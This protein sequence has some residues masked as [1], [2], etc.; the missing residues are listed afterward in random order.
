MD[1]KCLHPSSYHLSS[2]EIYVQMSEQTCGTCTYDL[3]DEW[4]TT[5]DKQT[6]WLMKQLHWRMTNKELTWLKRHSYCDQ[7]TGTD[8]TAKLT[9][10][11]SLNRPSKQRL[12]A[13][14]VNQLPLKQ[15][16]DHRL[17]ASTTLEMPTWSMNRPTYIRRPLKRH[18]QCAQTTLHNATAPADCAVGVNFFQGLI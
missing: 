18:M 12:T 11:D 10:F 14:T 15:C 2:Q 7:P 16:Q 17:A 1:R 8:S 3:T 4:R 5:N 13:R 9:W 6:T